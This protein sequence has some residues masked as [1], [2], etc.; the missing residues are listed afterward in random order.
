MIDLQYKAKRHGKW[1]IKMEDKYNKIDRAITKI[2]LDGEKGCLQIKKSSTPW[3]TKLMEQSYI[4]YYWNLKV[5]TLKRYRKST[6]RRLQKASIKAKI[7]DLALTLTEA[8]EGRALARSKMKEVLHQAKELRSV[9]L[10][11]RAEAYAEAGN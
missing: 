6:Q 7:A 1:T 2:M 5:S 9:E 10:L 8:Q 3:S 11:Q 4:L